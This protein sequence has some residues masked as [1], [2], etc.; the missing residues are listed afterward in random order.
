MI[1]KILITVRGGNVQYVA[2]NTPVEIILI[3]YDNIIDGDYDGKHIVPT[4]PDKLQP[5][6]WFQSQLESANAQIDRIKR[7]ND[8]LEPFDESILNAP[9]HPIT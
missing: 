1:P 6:A 3:D 2:S 8:G 7:I 9:F 5:E 4:G